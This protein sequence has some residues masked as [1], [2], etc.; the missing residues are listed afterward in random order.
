MPWPIVA[1]SYAEQVPALFLEALPDV[2]AVPALFLEEHRGAHHLTQLAK[3]RG[4]LASARH[5][6]RSTLTQG[7]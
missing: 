4:P 7:R 1:C 3:T 5:S 6:M 2:V